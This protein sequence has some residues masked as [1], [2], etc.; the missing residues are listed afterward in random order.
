MGL[1]PEASPIW[2]NSDLIYLSFSPAR[3]REIFADYSQIIYDSFQHRNNSF[4]RYLRILLSNVIFNSISG[5]DRICCFL[6][7]GRILARKLSWYPSRTPTNPQ[8]RINYLILEKHC[9]LKPKSLQQRMTVYLILPV[10]FLLVLMGIMGF[11][12]TRNLL[13]SQWREASVL[14]LQRAAHQVD[15]RLKRVKDWIRIFH[16][17][18]GIQEEESIHDLVIEKL[19][20]Q[21]GVDQ[22]HLAWIDKP[23]SSAGPGDR[24]PPSPGH[25][26]SDRHQG[27]GP[28]GMQ[29]MRRFYSAQ[30]REITPPRFDEV[31]NHETVSLISDLN[32]K[33]GRA[34]GRLEVVINFDVL[35]EDVRE[36]GWW[37]SNKAF[38]VTEEGQILA[39]TKS[40]KYDLLAESDD[41]L[42]RETVRA[43][44]TSAYGTIL[45]AGHPPKEVSG[46]CKLQEVSWRLVMIA[47]GKAI[48]APIVTFRFFYFMI[49]AGFILLIVVLI[50]TVTGRTAAAIHKVSK[51]AQRIAAG[52][53]GVFLV[54]RSRDEVGELIRSFNTMIQQLKERMEMKE[55]MNLA[56]EVQQNLL[57]KRIPQVEGLDIAARSIYC[58]ETG[59]D[60]YDF[61][62]I[63]DRNHSCIGIAVGD[64]S[65]HG[66]PAALLMASVRAFFR[67]RVRQPGNIAEIVSDVNHLVAK[68]TDETG[69][70]VTLFYA[71]ISSGENKLS[72]VRAGH[73]AALCYDSASDHFEELRGNGIALGIDK[74][75]K[76]E[77]NSIN[78]LSPGQILM[79]GTDGLREAQNEKGEMF[80]IERLKTLI[81]QHAR[82][83]AEGILA[84]MLHSVTKFQQ[85]MKQED[86]IT[87]VIV[88]IEDPPAQ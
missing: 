40:E 21:E 13:L 84:S 47:P 77:K 7:I 32:D 26:Y 15:M 18:S 65:G 66:I 74:N 58:D 17:T 75:F 4:S 52:D 69:H 29:M 5:I 24:H 12:Y 35:I 79:L 43:M 82:S 38:L 54:A 62:E 81:R 46:F 70:F 37:Q 22:V 86:D 80:G 20:L 60:L 55:A 64:V 10:T 3:V 2:P 59:G 48:L 53:Y 78:R 31:I 57:P 14:K 19:K 6:T 71:E 1:P 87:L 73:D 42:E 83:T 16:Q 25:R 56:M 68:D 23:P 88:K 50:R 61:L 67:S 34:I 85:S 36:S 63:A 49:S 51:A 27:Q 11:I 45:G 39:G 44:K 41:P 72:W 76:Y 33:N 8:I 30:I 28:K 9:M